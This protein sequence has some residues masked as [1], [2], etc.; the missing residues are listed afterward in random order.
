MSYTD[1]ICE[2]QTNTF[3]IFYSL[4]M[5]PIIEN[6]LYPDSA[7]VVVKAFQN[8][9]FFERNPTCRRKLTNIDVLT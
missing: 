6:F 3:R 2:F 5:E 7:I 9:N 4:L 1:Q 8:K